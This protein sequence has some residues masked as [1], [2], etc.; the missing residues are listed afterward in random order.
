MT[1]IHN[2]DVA[3]IIDGIQA[4]PTHVEHQTPWYSTL[5]L[6]WFQSE[7]SDLAE[8]MAQHKPD[9]V[10]LHL[11]H[12]IAAATMWLRAVERRGSA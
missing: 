8:A 11:T 1:F 6:S 7:G 12:V 2:A 5:R 4:D 9:E 10:A 3:R